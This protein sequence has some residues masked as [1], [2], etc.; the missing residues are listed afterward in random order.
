MSLPDGPTSDGKEGPGSPGGH[1][2]G[3]S[4]VGGPG[5]GGADGGGAV[6]LGGLILYPVVTLGFVEVLG[7]SLL[8]ALVVALLVE[9]L[10]ALAVAQVSVALRMDVVDRGA[11][12]LGS[13]VSILVVGGL[14]LIR[15]LVQGGP[16][17]LGLQGVPPATLGG[18]T[19]ATL[20]GAAVLVGLVEALRRGLGLRE[21]ALL[22]RLLPRT[23]RERVGFAGLSLVAGWGEE[24]AFRGYAIPALTP[25]FAGPWAAAVFT[26]AVFGILHAYQ[27]PM[28]ILRAALLGMILAAPFLLL[29]NLWPSVVAHVVIDLVGGF[30]LGPRLAKEAPGP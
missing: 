6:A 17:R 26:S 16:A 18:A 10:P 1:V 12:Y 22:S 23:T 4:G 30:W 8:D 29:G 3:D 11:A 28:G 19:L 20:A 2:P 27:G 21:S 24:V 5:D 15:G 9:L 7:A 14:A 25:L 13:A